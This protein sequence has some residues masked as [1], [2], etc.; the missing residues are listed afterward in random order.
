LSVMRSVCDL[1]HGWFGEK[2]AKYR[3]NETILPK[4]R[5]DPETHGA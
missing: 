1:Y 3:P 5:N 4:P 2:Q